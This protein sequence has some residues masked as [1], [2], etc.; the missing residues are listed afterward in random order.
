MERG[1]TTLSVARREKE[2]ARGWRKNRRFQKREKKEKERRTAKRARGDKKGREGK[3][4]EGRPRRKR[5]N[6]PAAAVC[7]SFLL[8][9][10]PPPP[11]FQ[12]CLFLSL[13]PPL[14]ETLRCIIHDFVNVACRCIFTALYLEKFCAR[15]TRY[16]EPRVHAVSP[17][18]TRAFCVSCVSSAEGAPPSNEMTYWGKRE[19]EKVKKHMEI[20]RD[21]TIY[22]RI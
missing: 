4:N 2:V 5:R 10:L 7:Y 14:R 22:T 11:P 12:L 1:G 9:P 15:E 6:F 19:R 3:C 20:E 8:H 21:G 16:R 18:E 13:L 17:G